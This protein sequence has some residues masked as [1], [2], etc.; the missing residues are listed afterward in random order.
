MNK[1]AIILVLDSVGIGAMPDAAAFGDTGAHTLGN[2]YKARGGRLHMPN[3]YAMGLGNITESGLP[4]VPAP[5]AAYGRMAQQTKAKDTTS[6]HWEIAG[7]IMD[8][9]FRTFPE[10]FPKALLDAWQNQSEIK[11]HL[12]NKPA[13]GTQIIDELGEAHMQTGMPIV[14]TSADSVFQIAAHEEVIPL[15]ELYRLCETARALLVDEYCVGR[16]IARPF[17][18]QPGD[19][20]RTGNR[21]DYA[22][23]PTGPTILDSLTVKGKNVLG[24]GKIEDIFCNRGVTHVNHTKTNIEGIDATIAA[25]KGT[26]ENAEMDLIFTNLV[27]FDMLYG[28]RNDVEG[29]AKAL[30]YFDTRLPEILAAMRPDDT[31]FITADHG[32]DPTTDSTDHSREYVPVLAYGTGIEP[33]DLGT[34]G[35]FAD[36]GAT[37][38]A[39]LSGGTWPVGKPF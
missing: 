13:S 5:T 28:H 21:K 7:L 35:T 8:T 22:V 23:E 29:Y 9:P 19:F 24:I 4:P 11:G 6:G 12:G 36:L 3:L 38:Y 26:F 33:R 32:C 1:R 34:R 37:V 2:I 16:V 18:G 25:L 17:I 15:K 30:E 10:G 20:K 14:Y 31:L 39:L 27:D